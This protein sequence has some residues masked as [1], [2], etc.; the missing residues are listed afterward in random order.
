MTEVRILTRTEPDIEFYTVAA[1][2]VPA[3]FFP[4]RIQNQGDFYVGPEWLA[5]C[6]IKGFQHP[7][8]PEPLREIFRDFMQV[9]AGIYD[10]TLDEWE[11]GFRMDRHAWAEIA[12]W[13]QRTDCLKRFASHLSKSSIDQQKRH[14]IYDVMVAIE[15][16][17]RE[18][19]QALVKG[20]ARMEKPG[21]ITEGRL[22]E[23]AEWMIADSTR[24]LRSKRREEIR[25]LLQGPG[26]HGPARVS[27]SA[28]LDATGAGFNADASFD[29]CDLVNSA[30]VILGVDVDSGR[31][32]LFYGRE[33]LMQIALE[34]GEEATLRIEIDLDTDDLERLAAIVKVVKGRHEFRAGTGA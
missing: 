10:R 11:E 2:Q 22:R 4:V 16:Q 1:D 7:E 32:F 31:E 17:Q 14:D 26:L 5:T 33:R 27:I 34:G 13:Q 29:P 8:F 21:S 9:F 6:K 30:D 12:I 19:T 15:N 3:G 28:L 24:K 25:R 18:V 20:K 23:I